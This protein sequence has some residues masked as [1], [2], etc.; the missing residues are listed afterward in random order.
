MKYTKSTGRIET[1]QKILKV[2]HAGEFGAINIYRA[3]ILI[4]KI[5]NKP[6]VDTLE[7]FLAD[8]KRHLDTFWKEIQIR[9]SPKCKSYWLC[10]LGGYAMGFISALLGKSGVMACTWAVESIV[11]KHL[12]EQLAYLQEIGDKDAYHVVNSII[13]DEK[14]HRDIGGAEGGK[15]IWFEPFRL[16]ISLFTEGVIRFGMR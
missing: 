11:T 4:S 12:I 7:S 10:G 13:E 14:L 5:F 8:E 9:K 1:A 3:Q 16:M 6:Y 2:D 15:N